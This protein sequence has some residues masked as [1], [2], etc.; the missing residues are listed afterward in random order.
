MTAPVKP[1]L[2]LVVSLAE[3]AFLDDILIAYLQTCI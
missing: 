3:H 1:F 2:I